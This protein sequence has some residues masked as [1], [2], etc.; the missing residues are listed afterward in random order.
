MDIFSAFSFSLVDPEPDI[1]LA[2]WGERRYGTREV[3][4]EFV[5]GLTVDGL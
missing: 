3:A 5:D 1:L 4:V 2:M